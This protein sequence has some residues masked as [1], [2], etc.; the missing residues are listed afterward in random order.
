MIMKRVILQKRTETMTR[1]ILDEVLSAKHSRDRESF[2]PARLVSDTLDILPSRSRDIITRRFGLDGR[3]VQTLDA[4]GKKY[5]ITRERVRQIENAVKREVLTR[6]REGLQEAF[7]L[8]EEVLRLKGEIA[9]EERLLDELLHPSRD[10]AAQRSASVFLL[11][12]G[13]DFYFARETETYNPYWHT[14]TADAKLARAIVKRFVDILSEK[15]SPIKTG[16]INTRLQGSDVFDSHEHMLTQPAILSYLDISKELAENPF[17][18]WGL[19][20]WPQ[21]SPR[22]VREKAFMV[23]EK[24]GKPLHF[25]EIAEK[26][27]QTKFDSRR[28]HPQTVHNE[29]IKDQRFV[30]V[31]RGVYA[32]RTWG[33]EP[34]TVSDVL[35]SV[36]KAAKKPLSKD[37]LVERVLAKR[38]VKRNTILL[39]LQDKDKFEKVGPGKYQL[40]K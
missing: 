25:A 27:N 30:L 29:L 21:I 10:S 17:S 35:K 33:Y 4:I 34:G 7:S 11:H 38:Q 19:K 5:G 22:G 16:E 18:E 12:I 32:L 3:Q 26:I 31:G 13:D 37:E 23:L 24:H 6:E 2:D 39:N 8:I 28:A 14:K 9:L 15:G 1:P 40:K 36:L 20:A